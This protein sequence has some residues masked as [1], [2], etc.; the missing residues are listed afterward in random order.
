MVQSENRER[1]MFRA[2]KPFLKPN[3]SQASTRETN[4]GFSLAWG[5]KIIPKL[6]TKLSR[7]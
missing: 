1:S 2:H 3:M 7:D 5:K 6:K 4:S